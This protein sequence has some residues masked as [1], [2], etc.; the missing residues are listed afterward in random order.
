M[1][2]RANLLKTLI[3]KPVVILEGILVLYDTKLRNMMDFKVYV[4]EDPDVRLAR[5]L[6]R[7]EIERE[8]KHVC[9]RPYIIEQC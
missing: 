4:D 7:D 9:P 1:F 6:R 5:R 2:F 3:P 8:S